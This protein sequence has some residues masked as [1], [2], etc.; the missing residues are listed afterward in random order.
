MDGCGYFGEAYRWYHCSMI[1]PHGLPGHSWSQ[2]EA[3]PLLNL[4]LP[5]RFVRVTLV[6]MKVEFDIHNDLHWHGVTLVHSGSEFVLAH[7]LYGFLIKS[8]SEVLGDVDILRVPVCIDHELKA[9]GTLKISLPRLVG[10]FGLNRVDDS[11]C[12]H[13]S[14]YA[15]Q[16][17]TVPAAAAR[18]GSEPAS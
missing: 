1:P 6:S 13:A 11:G 9:H 8:H 7:R 5:H 14:A 4:C 15:H 12:A 2:R 16:A 17:A 10:K 18:P 3:H